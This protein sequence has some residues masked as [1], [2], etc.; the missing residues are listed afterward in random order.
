MVIVKLGT[1]RL[2][3]PGRRSRTR[4]ALWSVL[5]LL[6]FVLLA[7][8]DDLRL[9]DTKPL[10]RAGMTYDTI[11][12]LKSLHISSAE[13]GEIAKVRNAG[14]SD[15][16]C[17]ALLRIFHQRSKPFT[18]G[19]AVAGLYLAGMSEGAVLGLANLDQV[20][21]GVG[22][23]QAM[24]LAGMP[25]ELVLDVARDRSLGKSTLSGAALGTMR[26]LRMENSTLLLLVQRGTPES[27]GLLI[28]AQR[29]RGAKDSE[30]LRH[31]PSVPSTGKD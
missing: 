30:I 2:R 17:I 8:C 23:L 14:L 18:A 21:V 5:I 31:F 12:E 20:G 16:D 24:H 7:S 1:S 27:D 10:D 6:S 26:N 22:E 9:L 3:G 15:G 19:D 28:I 13:V 11:K 4:R 29:R 25:D